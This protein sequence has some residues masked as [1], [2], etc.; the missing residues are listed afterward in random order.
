MRRRGRREEKTATKCSD[1]EMDL[2]RSTQG[3]AE[4]LFKSQKNNLHE[5]S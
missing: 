2:I 3:L 4:G 5:I 1:R